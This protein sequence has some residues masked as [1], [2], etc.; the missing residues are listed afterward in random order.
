MDEEGGEGVTLDTFIRGLTER[1]AGPDSAFVQEADQIDA[2][3]GKVCS[4]VASYKPRLEQ[5]RGELEKA[6]IDF[7]LDGISSALF[8]RLF[9]DLAAPVIRTIDGYLRL[10]NSYEMSVKG[11][12]TKDSEDPEQ[13][14][15]KARAAARIFDLGKLAIGLW[16]E[17]MNNFP[18]NVKE[19]YQVIGG[20]NHYFKDKFIKPEHSEEDKFK[21]RRPSDD[22]KDD[23]E[24]KYV[25]IKLVDDN[26]LLTSVLLEFMEQLPVYRERVVKGRKKQRKTR[27]VSTFAV[28]ESVDK[29]L[30]LSDPVFFGHLS[31]PKGFFNRIGSALE[32]FQQFCAG[33]EEDYK[34]MFALIRV[35]G[36]IGAKSFDS[37]VFNPDFANSRRYVR[38]IKNADFDAIVQQPDDVLPENRRETEYFALRETFLTLVHDAMKSI[39]GEE[40]SYALDLGN[41]SKAK[42]EAKA[43]SAE[44]EAEDTVRKAIDLKAKINAILTSQAMRRLRRDKQTD[45]EFYVGRQGFIGEFRFEREPVPNVKLDD[46]IG[47]SFDRAKQHLRE[48]V[49]TSTCPRILRLSAP[50]QKVRSNILLLGPYGCGKTELARA[51]CADTRVIGASV[52][53]ADTLTAWAHESVNNAKRIYE[54]AKK[55]FMEGREQKPVV[56]SLDEFDSWFRHGGHSSVDTDMQQIKSVLLQVLDGMQDYSGIVTLAMTNEPRSIPPGIV[57]RFRYVDVV[58]QLT[59][60]ERADMLRMYVERSLPVHPD[61]AKNYQA[62]AKML[63]DAPGDVV[64]KVIDEVHFTMVPGYI[65]EHPEESARIERILRKREEKRGINED[66]DIEYLRSRLAAHRT[67]TPPDIDKAIAMLLGQT[68]VQKQIR[69]AR[70]FYDSAEKVLDSLSSGKTPRFGALDSG[71]SWYDDDT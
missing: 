51:V 30:S 33:I 58:G 71:D 37:A 49:D 67:V 18:E 19:A 47:A 52:S 8:A 27:E 32:E 45:N 46:V 60:Q 66:E 13:Y 43:W 38:K 59:E 25:K 29:L 11:R 42:Q 17:T 56:L 9:H 69:K 50:G 26:P 70:D 7:D 68:H 36:A 63:A 62:W 24:I 40:R 53:V 22:E 10:A 20:F 6:R 16:F 4:K 34:A 54:A 23:K 5:I 15:R 2:V 57:R 35:S 64:R 28:N 65:R 44:K 39:S 21:R 48:I 12:L 41:S 31:S 61:V 1:L 3:L 14:A 55:L